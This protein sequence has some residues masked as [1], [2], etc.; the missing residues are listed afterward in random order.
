MKKLISVVLTFCIIFLSVSFVVGINPIASALT[1][2]EISAKNYPLQEGYKVDYALG[3]DTSSECSGKIST[4]DGTFFDTASNAVTLSGYWTEHRAFTNYIPL[5]GSGFKFWYKSQNSCVLR[6]RTQSN[7]LIMEATLPACPDGQWITYWYFGKCVN[8]TFKTDMSSDIRA[9]IANTSNTYRLNIISVSGNVFYIDEFF[10]FSPRETPADTYDNNEQAFKFSLKRYIKTSNALAEYFDDGSV[11]LSSNYGSATN[12]KPIE[13]YYNMDAEQFAN[14][15]A[16]ANQ[17]SG[18]LQIQVNN[19]TCLNSSDADAYAKIHLKMGGIDKELIK[20][21]YGSG[22]TDTYLIK[23]SDIEDANAVTTLY[24]GITGSKIKDVKFKISPIT[25]FHFPEDELILQAEYLNPKRYTNSGVL[26]DAPKSTSTDGNYTYVYANSSDSWLSFDLPELEVGEYEVYANCNLINNANVKA[27]VAV[28]NIRQSY[29]V[30]FTD[31]TYTS[32][33][34]TGNIDLGTIRITKSYQDGASVLKFYARQSTSI[35]FYVDYFSF[36]KT[37]TVVATESSSNFEIKDY[38]EMD[39]YEVKTVLN[40]FDT[41]ICGWDSRWY[42]TEQ[43]AGYVGNGTAFN[44]NSRGT[45]GGGFDNNWIYSNKNKLLDGNGLRFWYKSTAKGWLRF[46]NGIYSQRFSVEIPANNAG[47]WYTIY[48]ADVIDDGDMSSYYGIEVISGGTSYIDELHTIQEKI[49]D[50]T[51]EVKDDGTV[52][53]TGYNLRLEDVVIQSEYNGL[54]VTSIANGALAGSIT[55]KSVTLPSSITS[56]GD[57]V[58]DGCLNLKTINLENVTYIGDNAFNNCEK[59]SDIYLSDNTENISSSAFSGCDNL[60]INVL[61]NSNQKNYAI[62]N[63]YDYKCTTDKG[64]QYYR[65][66]TESS[67]TVKI[68]GYDSSIESVTVPSAIDGIDVVMIDSSAFAG[69]SVVKTVVLPSTVTKICTEAFAECTSLVSVEMPGVV[70]INDNAFYKC[71]SLKNAT[72]TDSLVTIGAKVFAHCT[73]FEK[74]YFGDGIN[75]IGDNAFYNVSP[76]AE[77]SSATYKS[78]TGYSYTYVNENEFKYYPDNHLVY[79][80]YVVNNIGTISGYK[81]N[82]AIVEI[83]ST[84]DGYEIKNVDE[85]AFKD[86]TVIKIVKFN[87]NMRNINDY[88]FY[89]CSSLRSITFPD[90]LRKISEYAFANCPLLASVSITNAVVVA[91]T[92]FDDTTKINIEQ[93]N[94][95]RNAFDYVE[96]MSAGWNLGNTLDAH[97]HQYSYGDL[98]VS[99]SEKLW[100][101]WQYISQDLFDLVAQKFNTIRIPITWNAFINPDDNYNIDVDYMDRIQ[102]VVDMCYKAGFKYIIINTHHDSDYYFNPNPEYVA[103][104][105]GVIAIRRVWEQI[106]ERFAD[107]D[108]RLIFESM[109]EIRSF[110]LDWSSADWNGNSTVYENYNTLNKIFYQTVRNSGGNNDKRYLMLQTYGGMRDKGHFSALWLPNTQTDDHIIGSFHWYIESQNAAHYYGI[111]GFAKTYFI[112]KGI[113]CVIGETG[114]PAYYENGEITVYN[115][116]AREKWVNVAFNLFEEY[117]LKAIIW[118]DHGTYSTVGHNSTD[119]YYWK[120]PKY[121]EAIYNLTKKPEVDGD[122]SEGEED[123]WTILLDGRRYTSVNKGDTFTFPESNAEGFI[124]YTDGENYYNPGDIISVNNN[125]SLYTASVGSITMKQGVSM[126]ISDSAGLRYYTIVEEDKIESLRKFGITVEMGTLIAPVDLLGGKE[127]NFENAIAYQSGMND[128]EF[129]CVDVKYTSSLYFEN[130]N[131]FVGSIVNISDENLNRDFVGR[132]YIKITVGN[133]EKIFYADYAGGSS[134]N[135]TR[136]IIYL[137]NCI[138]NDDAYFNTLGYKYQYIVNEYASKYKD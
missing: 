10:T 93:T 12:D 72:V 114:L 25:V 113:P 6:L 1:E 110:A 116:D 21:S 88:S 105:K 82:S 122:D 57:N 75:S 37:D 46:N 134:Q 135:N 28:N 68:I 120:F 71:T 42:D 76:V 40:T 69:N 29:D 125:L 108:E 100:R 95:M 56:I 9:S 96:G 62:N 136:N 118:E 112:D 87:E 4:E 104:G 74:F 131:T 63:G 36:K 59:L 51:Y 121:I 45:V 19:I 115:D 66:F 130:G 132:G 81:S 39:N 103:N 117:Q 101:H 80:Y 86:N 22:T 123:D 41:Y 92:A 61:N 16:V 11:T 52:T 99:E 35:A 91:E 24:V 8:F 77:M 129:Q 85:S 97:S 128:G 26:E 60:Y 126:R 78:K 138:K 137:V 70:T 67:S 13:I 38:P 44:L 102:E 58:F 55:L 119:G 133:I 34:H 5:T 20:Y 18:Y 124:C 90:S 84:I 89:N 54:P 33:R 65:D 17:D 94:F 107:Y 2:E 14:A 32:N 3:F 23:V 106:G 64:L 98:T 7:S 49:G 31:A 47:G 15:V 73:L 50:V 83:P 53:V 48:F 79:E 30:H 109:N 27:V 127:L 43:V 111:L